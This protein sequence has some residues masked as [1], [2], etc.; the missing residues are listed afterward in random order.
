[1]REQ[2][3]GINNVV[4]TGQIDAN[5]VFAILK[6]SDVLIAPY[7]NMSNFRDHL[8]NKFMEYC[9]AGKPILSSLSGLGKQIL[10]ENSAGDTYESK[11]DLSNIL[12]EYLAN[13]SLLKVKASNAQRLYLEKFHPDL[14]MKDLEGKIGSILLDLKKC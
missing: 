14:I 9:A 12:V 13:P 1:M 4:F 7:R 2:F 6:M 5:T 10:A 8:P 11:D 3:K